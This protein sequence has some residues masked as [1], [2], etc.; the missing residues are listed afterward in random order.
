VGE[1]R[2]AGAGGGSNS[3]AAPATAEETCELKNHFRDFMR[4][5]A[6]VK[7]GR[8]FSQPRDK[9]AGAAAASG[10]EVE[11][12]A[13]GGAATPT[14]SL[15]RKESFNDRTLSD[16][17][18]RQQQQQHELANHTKR[19]L[20]RKSMINPNKL[21]DDSD[22]D[23][24]VSVCRI[25]SKTQVDKY[26]EL[27]YSDNDVDNNTTSD[28][29]H[30]SQ[31][32][33]PVVVNS[34][35]PPLFKTTAE[36]NRPRTRARPKMGEEEEGEVPAAS[37]AVSRLKAVQRPDR[38][39]RSKSDITVPRIY[40]EPTAVA[41]AAAGGEDD[42]VTESAQSGA[43]G[44]GPA[45]S[46]NYAN[47]Q[48]EEAAATEEVDNN[49]NNTGEEEEEK[50][51][52]PKDEQCLRTEA[53]ITRHWVETST[54]ETAEVLPM[55]RIRKNNLNS[56]GTGGEYVY[57]SAVTRVANAR[58]KPFVAT[59]A[60]AAT[61]TPAA[62]KN[63]HA[64]VENHQRQVTHNYSSQYYGE[65]AP[66]IGED[67]ATGRKGSQDST[68]VGSLAN[69]GENHSAFSSTGYSNSTTELMNACKSGLRRLTYR[70]TYSRSRSGTTEP[71]DCNP[72]TNNNNSSSKN[73]SN[74]L[75]SSEAEPVKTSSSSS[76]ITYTQHSSGSRLPNRPTTPG[77]YLGADPH[78]SS[79]YK[80]PT[81]PG[82]FSR[83]SWKRTNQKFNY[84][85]FVSY[86]GHETYV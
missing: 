14:V 15:S 71:T 66:A 72:D 11:G 50:Q 61:E 26:T 37:A 82:P 43:V 2:Q 48:D 59:A 69:G 35:K 22:N 17:E 49:D 10:S 33:S 65:I 24:S 67:T 79:L 28:S 20:K 53:Q 36:T 56:Y 21:S 13:G 6:L 27:T 16:A 58:P 32:S 60:A 3:A 45:A 1:R 34:K 31:H 44:Q 70:K 57:V 73:Y 76:S 12:E 80:R 25:N 86:S 81:T 84:A 23:V 55:P 18:R 42:V 63:D 83:Q 75:E 54:P 52:T 78:T 41:E 46:L 39:T 68:A 40:G 9:A 19:F 77:P 51:S 62:L 8:S 30:T 5:P 47:C 4:T 7:R 74:S 29:R 38:R 85:K 64:E